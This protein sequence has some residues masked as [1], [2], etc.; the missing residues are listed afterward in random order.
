MQFFSDSKWLL[1]YSISHKKTNNKLRSCARHELGYEIMK[2]L[3]CTLILFLSAMTMVYAQ[4]YQNVVCGNCR[5]AGGWM[6]AYGPVYCLVCG[7]YGYVSVPVQNNMTFRGTSGNG[8]FTRT[9]YSVGIVCESGTNK[10]VYSI[11]LS[12]GKQY[13]RFGNSWVCIQGVN[14]FAYKGNRYYIKRG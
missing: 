11:Y 10:G 12:G 4:N 8:A 6:T 9:S 14:S 2:S 7:G 13:I 5:G 1:R 3:I